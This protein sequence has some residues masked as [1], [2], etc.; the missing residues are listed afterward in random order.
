[1]RAAVDDGAAI[2][3][4]HVREAGRLASRVR[5]LLAEPAAERRAEALP[6]ALGLEDPRMLVEGRLVPHVLLVAAR[7]LG[8]PVAVLVLVV[9]DD[10][11]L[12]PR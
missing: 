8:D 12:H 11:A 10:R 9:A 3:T 4:D 5:A 2:G 1:V 7:E 6:P